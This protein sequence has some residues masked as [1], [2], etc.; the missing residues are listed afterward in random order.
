MTHLPKAQ[1]PQVGT[2]INPDTHAALLSHARETGR[3]F[4]DVI[5]D[6]LDDATATLID[7]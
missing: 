1:W 6:V 7:N 5:R 4:A 3:T 2:R